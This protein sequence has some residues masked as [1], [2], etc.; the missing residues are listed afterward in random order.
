MK[1]VLV[2]V[3]T[4]DSAGLALIDRKV[5]FELA[6]ARQCL[7]MAGNDIDF[8]WLGEDLGTQHSPLIGLDLFREHIRPRHQRY[9]D[10]AKEFD[11]P[12]MIHSCGSSSWAYDDFIEMGIDAVDTL[13]PEAT[14]MSPD[15]RNDDAGKRLL[16]CPNAPATGQFTYTERRGHVRCSA[17]LRPLW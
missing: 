13:Q 15:P 12:V 14:D 5:E 11:K 6:V 17:S 3:V 9:V 4:G 10:L 7:E 2:D 1:Q 8:V 16:F